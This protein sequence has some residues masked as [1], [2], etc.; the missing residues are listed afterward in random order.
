MHLPS[1]GGE[2]GKS[3]GG[4]EW[5]RARVA[6]LLRSSIFSRGSRSAVAA[7]DKF[8]LHGWENRVSMST[9]H[10]GKWHHPSIPRH[11]H[12][13]YTQW[14]LV[15]A[16]F[17]VQTRYQITIVS[18]ISSRAS[19]VDATVVVDKLITRNKSE[20]H[21][22]HI[23]DPRG[24]DRG[25]GNYATPSAKRLPIMFYAFFIHDT[26][27]KWKRR[28]SVAINFWLVRVLSLRSSLFPSYNIRGCLSAK[29][30]FPYF[31]KLHLVGTVD[32]CHEDMR[33]IR[34]LFHHCVQTRLRKLCKRRYASVNYIRG[35][36]YGLLSEIFAVSN[37]ERRESKYRRL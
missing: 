20:R 35:F 16:D 37:V 5:A 18:A 24:W 29:K 13:P 3:A 36:N 12:Y 34:L 19:R 30:N 1:S 32:P 7:A 11:R 14:R 9:G 6:E 15:R 8:S 26:P 27:K 28:G 23:I 25:Q 2:R 4:K 33:I 21:A 31:L 10:T 22:E 17:R